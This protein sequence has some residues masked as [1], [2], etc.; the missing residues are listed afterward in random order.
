MAQKIRKIEEFITLSAE[1]PKVLS[2]ADYF[3]KNPLFTSLQVKNSGAQAIEGLKISITNENGLVTPYLKEIAEIPFESKVQVDL[4][5]L[6]SP[7]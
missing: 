3:M 2:Y 7:L 1:A 6:L 5:S 4:P